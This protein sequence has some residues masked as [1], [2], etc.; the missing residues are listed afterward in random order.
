MQITYF[1][2]WRWC[3]LVFLVA[4]DVIERPSQKLSVLQV[5]YS[6]MFKTVMHWDLMPNSQSMR[7]TYQELWTFECRDNRAA[8][9]ARGLRPNKIEPCAWT[10]RLFFGKVLE[11][12]CEECTKIV[13]VKLSDKSGSVR[14]SSYLPPCWLTAPLKQHDGRIITFVKLKKKGNCHNLAKM[15]YRQPKI[16]TWT[17]SVVFFSILGSEMCNLLF[18]RVLHLSAT[19]Q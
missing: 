6:D 14:L 9:H 18:W 7:N 17:N 13:K 15:N 4:R 10:V 2:A 19:H 11:L 12:T 3:F 1:Q 5:W 16:R 8:C